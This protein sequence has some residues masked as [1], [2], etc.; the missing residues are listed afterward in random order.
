MVAGLI[1]ARQPTIAALPWY[2]LTG[3]INER[4]MTFAIHAGMTA[5]ALV[6]WRQGAGFAAGLLLAMLA[7]WLS[8][9]PITMAQRGWLGPNQQVAQTIVAL[10]VAVCFLAALV[11]LGWLDIGRVGLGTL[12]Y[13]RA[14]CPGCG[15][16]FERRLVRG[17]TFGDQRYEPC[18]NCQKWHWTTRSRIS[19]AKQ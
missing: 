9:F 5:I 17:L 19:S 18:P 10:W 16:E 14:L 15:Y 1:A 6:V 11:L 3:F 4:L 13:G 8:N 2:Q 12:L 7:H